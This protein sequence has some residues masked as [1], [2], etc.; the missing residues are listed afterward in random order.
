M[1]KGGYLKRDVCT[2]TMYA[3]VL[4]SPCNV[5]LVR[6]NR[7]MAASKQPRFTV[8]AEALLGVQF[9]LG[10]TDGVVDN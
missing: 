1:Y 4:H 3:C 7:E 5:L 9:S 2:T 6:L 8:V 10:L